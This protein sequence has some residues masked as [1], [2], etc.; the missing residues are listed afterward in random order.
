MSLQEQ[1]VQLIYDIPEEKLESVI[2]I[3]IEYVP[4]KSSQVLTEKQK[5]FQEL[6]ALREEFTQTGI[7]VSEEQR[8]TA[9]NEK[10]GV[11]G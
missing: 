9:M 7:D 11:I 8:I 3:L 10:Y 5:A 4:V 1:A 2:H 6:M